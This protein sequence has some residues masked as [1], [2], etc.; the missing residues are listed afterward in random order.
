METTGIE[1]F[2]TKGAEYVLAIGFLLLLIVFWRLLYPSGERSNAVAE[3]DK[4]VFPLHSPEH[5]SDYAY[6][7]FRDRPKPLSGKLEQGC[8]EISN[9]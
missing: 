6:S 5:F 9:E 3:P 8:G 7:H 4:S 1:I 2:T